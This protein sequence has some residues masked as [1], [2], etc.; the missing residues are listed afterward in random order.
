MNFSTD[1]IA[2]ACVGF[3]LTGTSTGPIIAASVAAGGLAT[4][5]EKKSRRMELALY[6]T[7]RALESFARYKAAGRRAGRAWL[8][9]TLHDS[10]FKCG[11]AGCGFNAQVKEDTVEVAKYTSRSSNNLLPVA[12]SQWC[13]KQTVEMCNCRHQSMRK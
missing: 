4:L 3:G 7:S 12:D 1:C 6:C 13:S 10:H 9:Q 5:L 11:L 2:G 8:L